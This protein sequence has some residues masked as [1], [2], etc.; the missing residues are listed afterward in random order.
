MTLDNVNRTGAAP[1]LV[2]FNLNPPAAP[3]APRD[4]AIGATLDGQTAANTHHR[5]HDLG[6]ESWQKTP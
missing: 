2:N 5:H 3:A 6:E 4:G 1:A